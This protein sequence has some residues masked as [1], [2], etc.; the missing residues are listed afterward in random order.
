MTSHAAGERFTGL[1]R[2]RGARG[3]RGGARRDRCHRPPRALHTLGRTQPSI[4]AADRAADLAPVVLPDGRARRSGDPGSR[5]RP[6]SDRAGRS[7]EARAAR[8]DALAAAVVASPGSS[9]GATGCRSGTAT[10]ARRRTSP[11]HRPSAAA[12]ATTSCARRPTSS[13]PGSA[14]SCGRS[15]CSDGRTRRLSC[16]PSTRLISSPP[17]A[18]SSMLA[19]MLSIC[20]L[21][22]VAGLVF[23]PWLTPTRGRR[24]RSDVGRREPTSTLD[25]NARGPRRA[26]H[27]REPIGARRDRI[28][29][30]GERSRDELMTWLAVAAVSGAFARLNYFLY[31][32]RV[33]RQGLLRR[34]LPARVLRRDPVRGRPG[35]SLVLGEGLGDGCP[36][37]APPHRPRSPRRP[38]AGARLHRQEFLRSLD[39]GDPTVAR[40]SASAARASAS[41]GRNR[42]PDQAARRAARDRARPGRARHG[43]PR[44]HQH[45]PRPRPRNRAGLRRAT[46]SSASPARRSRMGAP[47]RGEPRPRRARERAPGASARER[48]RARVRSR[49]HARRRGRVWL[50]SMRERAA[51]I[52]WRVRGALASR[53]RDAGGRHAVSNPVRV[54]L[55]DDHVPTRHDIRRARVRLA[56]RRL[57]RGRRR[58]SGDRGRGTRDARHLRARRANAGQRRGCGLGDQLPAPADEDRHAH[59]VERRHGPVRVTSRWSVR[60][61]PEGHGPCTASRRARRCPE[62]RG[63]APARAHGAGHRGSSG[64]GARDGGR[65]SPKKATRR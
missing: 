11:R 47:R 3:G 51:R 9:G 38:G 53:E 35:D 14:R 17:P 58:A 62:R 54:L 32:L 34:L 29:A 65:C 40:V 43:Q 52:R 2:R 21:L 48:R 50:T 18:R 15:R 24:A 28:R 19:A 4:G 64:I 41:R 57:R 1:R 16:A 39:G 25:G 59:G 10:S 20:G 6:S 42:R 33:Y 55:A 22:L 60:L 12:P 27:R 44:G 31:P 36:R 26:A 63:R 13:T 56:I 7:L 30:Q 49:C 61:P 46:R 37:G 8:L 23:A 5:V 45:R